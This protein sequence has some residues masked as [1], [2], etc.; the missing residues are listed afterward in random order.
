MQQAEE[1]V[2]LADGRDDA[3]VKR[4]WHG[5]RKTISFSPANLAKLI[6][7]TEAGT[8]NSSVAKEVF[9]HV[10]DEDVDPEVYVE[11]NG[12]EDCQ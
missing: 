8:V 1:S 10:F 6:D 4:P 7:L 2:Q 5:S 9:E 12:L 3:S 11:E